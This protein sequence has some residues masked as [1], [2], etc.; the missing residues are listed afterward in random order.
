MGV[1][2]PSPKNDQK[3]PWLIESPLLGAGEPPTPGRPRGPRD[4]RAPKLE[5][6]RVGRRRP[7][8]LGARRTWPLPPARAPHVP[9]YL[10]KQHSQWW[11][12]SPTVSTQA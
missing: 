6:A 10:A 7:W 8:L 4:H 2:Q 5:R 3:G 11:P 1:P 9:A 12:R